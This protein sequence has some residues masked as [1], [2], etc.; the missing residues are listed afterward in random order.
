M[1]AIFTR[2][3]REVDARSFD[4]FTYNTR[5]RRTGRDVWA[6][7]D[8]FFLPALL[9]AKRLG[10]IAAENFPFDVSYGYHF[11][12]H[13]VGSVLRDH[14][15]S[16]GVQHLARHIATVVVSENGEVAALLAK[17][18]ERIAGDFFIDCSGFRGS[19]IQD[20]LGGNVCL[21]RR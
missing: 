10:P 6:H 2:L 17:H 21:V 15:M 7:P 1:K 13:L 5:A 14:A 18:G 9:S 11:D 3:R 19:I 8:R 20:A 12:A 16:L 4:S